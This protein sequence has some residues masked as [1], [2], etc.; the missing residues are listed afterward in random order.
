MAK[1]EDAEKFS[2]LVK[3]LNQLLDEEKASHPPQPPDPKR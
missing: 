3:E 1:E 2:G